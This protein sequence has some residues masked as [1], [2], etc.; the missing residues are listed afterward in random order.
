MLPAE[1]LLEV[2]RIRQLRA[3]YCHLVDRKRWEEWGML[4]TEGARLAV[5][6][7]ELPI[8]IG[9]EQIVSLVSSALAS[10]PTAHRVFEPVI[11]LRSAKSAAGVWPME[12]VLWEPRAGG[13]FHAVKR[14]G[15]YLDE[16]QKVDDAWLFDAVELQ[17]APFVDSAALRIKPDEF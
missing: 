4:F 3:R 14:T 11:R 6:G 7:S 9:R 2:H 13:E 12:D 8:L 16:Y 10:V 1:E 15:R 17:R 5:G